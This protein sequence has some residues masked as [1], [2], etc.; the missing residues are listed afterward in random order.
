MLQLLGSSYLMLCISWSHLNGGL[1]SCG[2]PPDP[3]TYSSHEDCEAALEV[4]RP[5]META[6]KAWVSS[7]FE[8]Q[9][10]ASWPDKQW[11]ECRD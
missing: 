11:I 3:R 9:P 8:G 7:H 6:L 1:R 2:P 4:V 5:D 10:A